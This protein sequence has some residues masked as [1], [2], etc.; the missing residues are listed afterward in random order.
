MIRI[1]TLGDLEKIN[2]FLLELNSIPINKKDLESNLHQYIGYEKDNQI[3]GFACYSIYYDRA[4]ID[5]IYTLNKYRN[6][7]I[8]NEL[9]DYIINL[10]KNKCYNITL[11]VGKSNYIAIKLYEKKGFKPVKIIKNYYND[12]DGILMLKE[13][14]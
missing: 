6:Q 10:C 7:N 3:I 1:L 4:E 5:Y 13:L 11:E 14:D 2:Q 9:L 12:D 8:G